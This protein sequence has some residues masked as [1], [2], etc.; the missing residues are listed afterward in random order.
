MEITTYNPPKTKQCP[1]CAET[2]QA[3]AVKCRFCNEFLNSNKAR[4]L[5]AGQTSYADPDNAQNTADRILFVGRPSLLAMTGLAIR[6][7]LF[8]A[9]A[10]FLIRYPIEELSIFQQPEPIATPIV[11]SPETDAAPPAPDPAITETAAAKVSSKLALNEQQLVLFRRYRIIAGYGLASL[12]ILILLIKMANLKATS[13]E[14][15]ADR[16]EWSRGLL[17]RKVDNLDMFRIIDLKL[18]R[19]LLD[20]IVGIGTVT[21]ITT[22]KTDPEFDFEKIRNPRRLY[23]VIKKASLDADRRSST[24]HLE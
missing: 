7:L 8:L 11:T 20:C 19:S 15:S 6:G 23:D 5:Q 17:D 10:A 13:Y 18:R 2:I 1:F 16:I 9:I 12:V 24:V 3:A 22:D 14:V 4:A 21:V